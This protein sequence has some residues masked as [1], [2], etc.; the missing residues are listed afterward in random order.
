MNSNNLSRRDKS[1]NTRPTSRYSDPAVLLFAAI[2]AAA[3]FIVFLPALSNQ[4]VNWDDYETLVDNPHYRG[5]G[6][7]N[8][9]WMFTTFHMGHYQPLS[10]LTFALDYVIWGTNPFGYHLTN[11]VLHSANAVVFFFLARILLR[12]VFKLA[13]DTSPILIN[14]SAG[15]AAL[16]FSIHPLRVESV[17][18]ATERWDFLSGLFFLLTVYGYVRAQTYTEKSRRLWSAVTFVSFILSLLAKASAI[19]LPVV[20]LLI[21]V[22]PLRR[23]EGNWRSWT[24]PEAKKI[25][26]E[27]MPFAILAGIFAL[28]AILAQQSAGAL[29][30]VQQY[31]FSYRVGQAFYGVIFYLWKSILPFNLSPLYELPY[32]FDAWMPLFL[33]CGAAAAAISVA[34]YALRRRWPGA[35]AAW[36]CYLLLLA[37]VAGIAQSGPQLVADRYSY[38]SCMSW[39]VLLGGVFYYF[40][41]SLVARSLDRSIIVAAPLSLV[42]VILAMMSWRQSEIWRDTKSLWNHVIA[43]APESSYAHYNLGRLLEDDGQFVEALER[44]RRALVS[45]PLIADAHYNLAR[46]LAKQNQLDEAA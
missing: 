31:F 22:Y 43:V 21:D 12:R 26:W 42:L 20:L 16:L 9:R 29:R 10:W 25:F 45:N 41:G 27:K 30:P 15:L 2:V 34:L 36:I 37:P 14:L 1:R 28:F 7:P 40:R 17:V 46:L 5:L 3:T 39:A 44:Y 24:T 35:L 6:W 18:W 38:F 4:F 13:D 11:L 33:F 19:T 8:L 23:L 32:D